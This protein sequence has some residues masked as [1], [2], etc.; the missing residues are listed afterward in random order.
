MDE[1]ALLREEL[2]RQSEDLAA[3]VEVTSALAAGGD[4]QQLVFHVV[5]RLAGRLTGERCSVVLIDS[6][7]TGTVLVASDDPAVREK[8]I[9]LSNYPA[10]ARVLIPSRPSASVHARQH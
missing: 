1:I 10:S 9:D 6:D 2:Q 4:P 5:E 3:L 7:G 8:R